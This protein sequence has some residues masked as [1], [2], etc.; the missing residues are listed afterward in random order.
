[1]EGRE[2]GKKEEGREGTGEEEGGRG[3]GKEEEGGGGTGRWDEGGET[4]GEDEG[5][6]YFSN[7]KSTVFM[8]FYHVNNTN[9][10]PFLQHFYSISTAF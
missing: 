2:I 6:G 7:L 1:M 9:L 8:D 10:T 4:G 3:T 5:F